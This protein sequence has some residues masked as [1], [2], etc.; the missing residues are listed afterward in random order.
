MPTKTTSVKRS[1]T[2]R[3]KH[4]SRIPKKEYCQKKASARYFENVP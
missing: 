1:K 4:K 3:E 2:Y